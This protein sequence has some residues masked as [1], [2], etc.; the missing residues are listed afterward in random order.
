MQKLV[1]LGVNDMSTKFPSGL[2][3]MLGEGA[4]DG[5][6]VATRAADAYRACRA[7]S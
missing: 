5:K 1:K 7:G 3:T 6:T 2:D 4:V